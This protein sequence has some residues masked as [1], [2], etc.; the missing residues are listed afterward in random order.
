MRHGIVLDRV[1]PL[2]RSTSHFSLLCAFHRH[3]WL[4]LRSLP[5]R[6]PLQPAGEHWSMIVSVAYFLLSLQKNHKPLCIHLSH[7]LVTTQK[8]CKNSKTFYPLSQKRTVLTTS[9]NSHILQSNWLSSSPGT[10]TRTTFIQVCF[11]PEVQVLESTPAR[12]TPG[13]HS[14]SR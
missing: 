7:Q 3:R 5:D 9:K 4:Q 2:I 8:L 10:S 14:P 13:V 12:V 6:M 11:V 1:D